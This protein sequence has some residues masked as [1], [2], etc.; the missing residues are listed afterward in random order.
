MSFHI[1]NDPFLVQKPQSDEKLEQFGKKPNQD[2][3]HRKPS[4]EIQGNHNIYISTFDNGRNKD[5][6]QRKM[7]DSIANKI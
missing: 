7:Y 2:I 4:V 3:M 1:F 6:H 5:L